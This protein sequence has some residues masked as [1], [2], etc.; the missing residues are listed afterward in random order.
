[1]KKNL[2]LLL[3]IGALLAT[4]CK[5]KTSPAVLKTDVPARPAGQENVIGLRTEPLETVRIGVVGLGMR[6]GDAVERLTYVPGAVVTALCDVVPERVAES[7]AV[8]AK[9][10]MPAA[11]EYTGAEDAYKA[12]CQQEDLST[13][14]SKCPPRAPW[15]TSG[16][17]STPPSARASTA[18]CWRTAA[19][20]SSS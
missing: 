14:P 4:A 1:M 12:L 15:R 17:S 11:K 9:R 18:S 8:L 16:P 19:M 6:G 13:P 3:A 20:T 10:G 2:L 7:Q 5:T